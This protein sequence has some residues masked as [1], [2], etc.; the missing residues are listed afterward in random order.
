M[1]NRYEIAPPKEVA[2]MV[3]YPFARLAAAAIFWLSSG[4]HADELLGPEGDYQGKNPCPLQCKITGPD[5]SNWPVYRSLEKLQRCGQRFLLSFSASDD[6]DDPKVHHRI[7]ACTLWGSDFYDLASPSPI[8]ATEINATLQVGSWDDVSDL[9]IVTARAAD[10]DLLATQMSLY[11]SNGHVPV[12]QTAIVYGLSGNATFG[13]YIGKSLQNEGM[14]QVALSLFNKYARDERVI[15]RNGLAMQLCGSGRDPDHAFGAITILNGTFKYVQDAI[16][17]WSNG[18]CLDDFSSVANLTAPIFVTAPPLV[19]VSN[20]TIVTLDTVR[21]HSAG[22][23][24]SLNNESGLSKRA[25]CRTISV[26]LNDGCPGL[27][28]KCGISAAD[29]TKYNPKADCTNLQPS[30]LVCCSSGTLP[31]LTSKPNA[32]GSCAWYES[33]KD[34]TCSSIAVKNGITV[35]DLD[36]FNTK[37]WGWNGCDNVLWEFVRMCISTGTPPMPAA[38]ANSVCGPQVPGT[39][40]P[41]IG[42]DF[43]TLNPCPLNAC[44]DVWAQCGTTTEFCVDTTMGAPGTAKPN[45]NGCI[46][47]CG[48]AVVRGTAPA[49]FR[50]IAYFQGYNLGRACLYMDALQVDASYTHVHF[51]FA[52]L[53][54]DF[55][56]A[57]GDDYTTYEYGNFKTLKSTKRILSFGGWDFSTKP[58]TYMIFRNG[59]NA[60]NRLTMA[61]NIAN[62]VNTHNLDG[63]DIDWEYPGAPDLPDIPKAD[64]SDGNNYLAFLIILKGLLNGKSLSIAAPASYWYLKGFPIAKIS[65]VVDYIVYMTYD[66]H[67]QWDYAN[68]WSIP[69]CPAGNCLRSNVNA[70]ETV[71]AL[72]MITK[73]GVPSNKVVVGVTSYGRSYKM[74]SPGCYGEMC[75]FTGLISGAAKGECTNEPGYISNAEISRIESEG[76]VNTKYVDSR[77]QSNILVYDDTEWVGYMDDAT[78]ASR[79]TLYKSLV[80]GGTT[81]WAT[82]LQE[83]KAVPAIA[84]DTTWASFKMQIKMGQDPYKDVVRLGNWSSLT[85]DD[86]AAQIKNWETITTADRWAQLDADNAWN[87]AIEEWKRKRDGTPKTTLSFTASLAQTFGYDVALDCRQVATGSGCSEPFACK[88]FDTGAAGYIIFNS[89]MRIR[90]LYE[91]F[92]TAIGAMSGFLIGTFDQFEK[93]FA[94]VPVE[95]TLV[96]D[97]FI[98]L[99][100]LGLGM[101]GGKAMDIGLEQVLKAGTAKDTVKAVGEN[102]M[103]TGINAAIANAKATPPW[104]AD[105]QVVFK[106][107]MGN[108]TL[109]WGKSTEQGLEKM[110]SGDDTEIIKIYSMI[111][112]GL[113]ASQT[114]GNINDMVTDDKTPVSDIQDAVRRTFYSMAIPLAWKLSGHNPFIIDSG[115]DCAAP[116]PTPE[117]DHVLPHNEGFNVVCNNNKQ[118]YIAGIPPGEEA[119]WTLPGSGG[120]SCSPVGPPCSTNTYINNFESLPGLSVLDGIN[121]GKITTG[122]IVRGALATYVKFGNKNGSPAADMT[123]KNTVDDM[124]AGD[125]T[126]PGY[127]RLPVCGVLEA[128]ANWSSDDEPS[129]NYPCN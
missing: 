115:L 9:G 48:T 38:V 39:P 52:T 31:D 10:M 54:Q 5:S 18:G 88:D 84:K 25:E 77:S 8:P 14:G 35:A 51:G 37:T 119:S 3:R 120:G 47:N 86:P 78:K 118:Y 34:D 126:T 65:T 53:T 43:S 125:I 101:A 68:K 76:R 92:H 58:A 80:M 112:N 109:S 22:V 110:F 1:R 66:L 73:A 2:T 104:T 33:K 123:K 102:I 29:F 24:R 121:Y 30:Q 95:N 82:D 19:P 67:G 113:L 81:D 28:V 70:T 89:L 4:V 11:F 90:N 93:D 94:P 107:M 108:M 122:E 23:A 6:V 49:V 13:V 60:A 124:Y 21:S 96:Q 57:T 44:C 74:S 63:V 111:K 7:R 106:F 69:G 46:S 97:I 99:F 117:Q 71:N 61:K 128:W 98:G 45:T 12:N 64:L 27:A 79:T 114:I 87:N 15:K 26:I 40:T 91:H 55:Q 41:P 83:F 56:V 75:T 16:K 62:F 42:T 85:C 17:T 59:V 72:S 116:S 100:T 129:D 105:D 32:D 50:K 127:I 103:S 36:K 20:A